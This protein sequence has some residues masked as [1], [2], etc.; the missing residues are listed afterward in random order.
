VDGV[1]AWGPWDIILDL[2]RFMNIWKIVSISN[3]FYFSGFGIDND[4][5][6]INN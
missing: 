6:V 5:T 4:T 2:G 3:N 1:M